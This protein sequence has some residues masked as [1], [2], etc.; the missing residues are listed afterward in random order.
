MGGDFLFSY[1]IPP[2]KV[3]IS[4]L[5]P[6]RKKRFFFKQLNAFKLR[7]FDHD[8]IKIALSDFALEKLGL[9]GDV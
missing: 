4:D 9:S 5:T 6:C 3:K 7:G 2:I 1:F 8:E